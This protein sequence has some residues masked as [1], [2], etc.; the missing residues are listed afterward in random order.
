M[1]RMNDKPKI[2]FSLW[3]TTGRHFACSGCFL[4]E[5]EKRTDVDSFFHE[6]P[7]VLAEKLCSLCVA[8]SLDLSGFE[9]AAIFEQQQGFIYSAGDTH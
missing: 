1:C 7:S 2:A 9:L 8:P 4:T 3:V 6:W 5:K